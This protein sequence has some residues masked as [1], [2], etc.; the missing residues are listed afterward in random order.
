MQRRETPEDIKN[1]SSDSSP[2]P[3]LPFDTL[4]SSLA[5][6]LLHTA[7]LSSHHSST[8]S[9]SSILSPNPSDDSSVDMSGL[10]TPRDIFSHNPL[11]SVSAFQRFSHRPILDHS[12]L[13][14]LTSNEMFDDLFSNVFTPSWQKVHNPAY[15]SPIPDF[16]N[17][18]VDTGVPVEGNYTPENTFPF[19]HEAD[20]RHQTHPMFDAAS[21]ASYTPP[22]RRSPEA[23]DAVKAETRSRSGTTTAIPPPTEAELQSYREFH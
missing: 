15:S 22:L 9:S 11:D 2:S 1:S 5:Y 17:M 23:I 14:D 4:S 21:A 12:H 7:S 20:G 16:T 8:D 13:D 19:G 3:G 6:P 10:T 18:S